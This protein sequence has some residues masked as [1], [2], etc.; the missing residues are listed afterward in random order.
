MDQL[1][2]VLL[3]RNF[4]SFSTSEKVI[5]SKLFKLATDPKKM[6][7]DPQPWFLLIFRYVNLFSELESNP[8]FIILAI[9]SY[10]TDRYLDLPSTE[11]TVVQ[12]HSCLHGVL[13]GEL[14]VGKPLGVAIELIAQDGHSEHKQKHESNRDEP[15]SIAAILLS[16]LC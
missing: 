15:V 12:S 8:A 13:V 9:Y 16:T 4:C 14:H 5:C 7:A 11:E 6:N 3:F 2:G 1:H 10:S